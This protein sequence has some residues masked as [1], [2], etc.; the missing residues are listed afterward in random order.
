MSRY[1]YVST[2]CNKKLKKAFLK[3]RLSGILGGKMKYNLYE[4]FS[5]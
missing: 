1:I 2:L 3:Y 5:Q 4:L